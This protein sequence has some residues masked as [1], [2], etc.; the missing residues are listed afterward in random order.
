M[1]TDYLIVGQGLSGSLLG[2]HLWA[3]GQEVVFVERGDEVT[4]S[5]VAA[6]IVT[7][8]TGQ[9]L[10]KSWRIDEFGPYAWAFYE[11]FGHAVGQRYFY[12]K[13]VVRFFTGEDEVEIWERKKGTGEFEGYVASEIAAG[14]EPVKGIEAPYGGFVMTRSGYLD[15]AGFVKATA[16]YFE[17]ERKGSVIEAEF[18]EGDLELGAGGEGA[19]W[20]EVKVRKAVV[21]CRGFE[22]GV[23]SRFFYWVAINSAQ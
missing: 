18:E 12:Q 3:R 14:S 11:K 23:K 16:R 8:I 4:S 22:E 6:G 17:K 7:P 15:V 13:P 1:E 20:R 5:K 2:W 10:V 19:T 9:R 21:F